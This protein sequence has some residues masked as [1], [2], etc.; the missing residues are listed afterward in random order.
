MTG[1]INGGRSLK[2]TLIQAKTAQRY[3]TVRAMSVA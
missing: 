1:P 3:E 2:L